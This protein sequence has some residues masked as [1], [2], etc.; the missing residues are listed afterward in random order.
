MIT[1]SRAR[2]VCSSNAA[3]INACALL[4]VADAGDG[5]ARKYLLAAQ[6]ALGVG[7]TRKGRRMARQV[8]AGSESAGDRALQAEA[9]LVLS[10]AYVLES[11]LKLAHETS[12]RAHALFAR[13][14]NAAGGAEALAIYSYSA[15]ALGLDGPA[16]QAA[17]DSMSLRTDAASALAQARGLNYMGVASSWTRDFSTARNALEAS[18]W[19]TRQA[20]DPAAGFQPLVNLCFA[21]VLQTVEHE[22]LH[23]QPADLAELERL[24]ARARAMASSGQ[25][26]GFHKGALD[27]G[28]L[29]LEFC[30]CFVSSRLGRTV[31]A[32]A[33]YLACLER[34]ARFPRTSWVHAVLW[35]ARLER[36][37][38]Y[39]DIEAS[40]ASLHAMGQAAKAGEHVQLQVLAR[41]LEATLRPPLNQSD[42]GNMAL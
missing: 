20:S 21:E 24:L 41:T 40:I 25:F 32:D 23:Q 1:E 27:I 17:C 6:E 12:A 35:W 26:A 7:S 38:S 15:S 22:R 34:A 42:S 31:D 16:L 14:S 8:L 3:E 4:E 18:I 39:G 5:P 29:V 2:R 10:R 9:L 19:F 30:S 36:A 33:H 28:L 13:E 11:R 37:V